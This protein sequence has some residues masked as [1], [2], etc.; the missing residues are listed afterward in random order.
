MMLKSVTGGWVNC[1]LANGTVIPI[2]EFCHVKC[3]KTA[4]GR[5]HFT[6]QEGPY[7]KKEASIPAGYLIDKKHDAAA[8]VSFYMGSK[9]FS[10]KGGPAVKTINNGSVTGGLPVFTRDTD[11]VPVGIWDIETP[12]FP[13]DLGK[14]YKEFASHA[15]S[16][17]RIAS[18]GSPNRFIHVGTISEGC[19]TV[20]IAADRAS[21]A[22]KE[23]LRNYEKVYAYLINRRK[24]P[25]IV[26]QLQVFPY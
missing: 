23:A 9:V 5:D 21:A 24:S 22:G 11:K 1:K 15:L 20:G 10:W 19:A 2:F 4:T 3:H 7:A 12:D 17:F 18:P 14:G 6:F 13:H 8:L 26:G 25:G 16:W